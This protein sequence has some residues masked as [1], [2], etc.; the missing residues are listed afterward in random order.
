MYKIGISTCGDKPI[1]L[2]G[3]TAMKEA[4]MGAVEICLS[5]YKELDFKKVKADAYR[6]R[7]DSRYTKDATWIKQNLTRFG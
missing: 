7:K 4:G 3:F 1:D 6:L 2:K 5:D